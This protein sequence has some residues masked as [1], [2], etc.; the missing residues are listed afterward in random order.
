MWLWELRA[1][2]AVN[3]VFQPCEGG[4]PACCTPAGPGAR[5]P[6]LSVSLP[7]RGPGLNAPEDLASLAHIMKSCA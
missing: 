2:R 1:C 4:C 7:F 3:C 5:P 6:R